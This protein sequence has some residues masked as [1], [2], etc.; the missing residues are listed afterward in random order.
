MECGSPHNWEM[1]QQ[2]LI[3]TVYPQFNRLRWGMGCALNIMSTLWLLA[4]T[5]FFW[6]NTQRVVVDSWPL[7]MGCP[8]TLVRD[9]HYSL[10]NKPEEHSSI[11]FITCK[12]VFKIPPPPHTHTHIYIS[13]ILETAFFHKR[14]WLCTRNVMQCGNTCT[15]FKLLEGNVITSPNPTWAMPLDP[16]LGSCFLRSLQ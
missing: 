1:V 15:V 10:R 12:T 8:E 6:V 9:Y 13:A 5:A 3:F 7:K 16:T 2:Q 14:Q 4:S 11:L